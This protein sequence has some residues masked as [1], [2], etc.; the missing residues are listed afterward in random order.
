[1]YLPSE[2]AGS[3]WVMVSSKFF[4]QRMMLLLTVLM[5]MMYRA[6]LF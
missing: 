2:W 5:M 6:K 1:M 3:L 4:T